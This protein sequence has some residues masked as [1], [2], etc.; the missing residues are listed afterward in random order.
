VKP[1]IHA[2]RFDRRE[3]PKSA[4]ILTP[5]GIVQVEWMN[6]GGWRICGSD[7]AKSL[8]GPVIERIQRRFETKPRARRTVRCRH[9][10]RPSEDGSG[11]C[12]RCYQTYEV[13]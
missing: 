8:A 2:I 11:V 9:C 4:V 5:R 6:A 1:H 7:G 3:R 12:A 10:G 13:A